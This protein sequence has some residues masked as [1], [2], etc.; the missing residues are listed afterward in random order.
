VGKTEFED[1][2]MVTAADW[3]FGMLLQLCCSEVFTSF[4]PLIHRKRFAISANSKT[5]PPLA[6]KKSH[7]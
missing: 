5:Y 7:K 2:E 3:E 1:L 4:F 6:K